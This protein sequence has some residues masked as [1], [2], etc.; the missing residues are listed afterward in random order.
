VISEGSLHGGSFLCFVT[1]Q[2]GFE[3][4]TN[5]NENVCTFSPRH[6]DATS[7]TLECCPNVTKSINLEEETSERRSKELRLRHLQCY[8]A[9]YYGSPCR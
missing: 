6:V 5:N 7:E 2:R 3:T 4:T 1:V 8:F 9:A